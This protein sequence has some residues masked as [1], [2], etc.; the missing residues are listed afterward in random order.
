V[1]RIRK[2]FER[3]GEYSAQKNEKNI[4]KILDFSVYELEKSLKITEDYQR[5]LE[6][7]LMNGQ[8]I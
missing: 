2:V 8:K 1:N 3:K 6:K 4:L 5:H 7:L